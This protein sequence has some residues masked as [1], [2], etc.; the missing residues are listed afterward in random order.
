MR[1][2]LKHWPHLAVLNG[3]RCDC[4][5]SCTTVGLTDWDNHRGDKALRLFFPI[6][7]KLVTSSS[8]NFKSDWL[9]TTAEKTEWSRTRGAKA[10]P[11]QLSQTRLFWHLPSTAAACYSKLQVIPPPRTS[12]ANWDQ[13][14]GSTLWRDVRYCT[15]TWALKLPH[16][17]EFR[18]LT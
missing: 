14:K 3:R 4:H 18:N 2:S 16:R 12:P 10:I 5:T 13:K 6:F 17:T 9:N 8:K 15:I 1:N 7:V 11:G